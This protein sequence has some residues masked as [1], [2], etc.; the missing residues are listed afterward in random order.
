MKNNG[1]N[2]KIFIVV[3]VLIVIILIYLLLFSKHVT[4]I[5]LNKDLIK[6]YESYSEKLEARVVPDN[7]SAELV[8]ESSNPSIASVNEEGVVLGIKSGIAKIIVSTTDGEISSSC[9]VSVMERKVKD[10]VFDVNEINI[11]VGENKQITATIKPDELKNEKINWSSSNPLVADVDNNGKVTGLE[12]GVSEIKAELYG[13]IKSILAYIGTKINSIKF[14]NNEIKIDKNKSLELEINVNPENSIKEE[15]IWESSDSDIVSVDKDGNITAKELG[16]A[17]ITATTMYS[18]IKDTCEVT[19]D[20]E[21]FEIVYMEANKTDIKVNGE[22]LGELPT[23]K[24]SGYRLLGWYT[25]KTGGKMVSEN[26]IVESNMTLYPHWEKMYI[27]PDDTSKLNG[28]DIIVSYNSDTFKYKVLKRGGDNY[29]IIWVDD[30]QEQFRSALAYPNAIGFLP[31]EYILENEIKNKGYQNKGLVSVNA[32]FTWFSDLGSPVVINDGKILRDVENKKYREYEMY[33][34]LGLKKDGYLATYGFKYND[35]AYNMNTRN[36]MLNDGIKNVFV[37]SGGTDSGAKSVA[38]RTQICQVD[39]HN[40]VLFS[41]NGR[42]RDCGN[43]TK[44]FGC[45]QVYNLDGGGS[46]KLYYK[47]NTSGLVKVFGGSRQRP[48]MLYFVEK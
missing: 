32:S 13:A 22:K 47:T 27:L 2:T 33:P 7:V 41:G 28:Y 23:I 26:T 31:A 21:K 38:H 37:I 11:N 19:V 16:T 29:A 1:K 44:V 14:T 43:R 5:I 45:S 34:V 9:I 8:W 36:Q 3:A 18:K 30:A 42:I 12:Q 40:F 20:K 4:G 35:Y 39:L 10:L 17:T 24:K 15:I 48:D 6:I 46:R 25:E